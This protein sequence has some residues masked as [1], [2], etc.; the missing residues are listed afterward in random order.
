MQFKQWQKYRVGEIL[1][2]FLYYCVHLNVY[3]SSTQ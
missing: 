3:Y 2:I 1:V